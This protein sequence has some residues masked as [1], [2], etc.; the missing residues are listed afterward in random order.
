MNR[1]TKAVIATAVAIPVVALLVGT[2]RWLK[3]KAVLHRK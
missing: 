1:N 2:V 3:D